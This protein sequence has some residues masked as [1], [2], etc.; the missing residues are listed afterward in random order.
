MMYTVYPSVLILSVV[1]LVYVL[2]SEIIIKKKNQ[3]V[4]QNA[5]N[6]TLDKDI[7]DKILKHTHFYQNSWYSL[8]ILAT[9]VIETAIYLYFPNVYLL[10]LVP[11]P[12]TLYVIPNAIHEYF[13]DKKIQ[14]FEKELMQIL[15]HMSAVTK[16]GSV[17]NALD[18]VLNSKD[19]LLYSPLTRNCLIKIYKYFTIMN[20]TID[21][22]FL[23]VSK[24]IPS[25]AFYQVAS[26]IKIGRQIGLDISSILDKIVYNM[27][28]EELMRKEANSIMMQT[29]TTSNILS[30]APFVL[31]AFFITTNRNLYLEYLKN[32]SNQIVFL[33]ILMF[34]FVGIYIIR[35][36]FNIKRG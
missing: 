35:K 7:D 16:Y 1:L 33:G 32:T 5:L 11:L 6:K 4:L 19:F 10:L 13:E 3:M 34:L 20:E 18:D 28:K 30:I 9:I 27:Q 15:R 29:K 8:F 24:E 36:M 14:Q 25:K 2:I 23:K 17:K 21:D 26:S 31:L 12:F 22:A